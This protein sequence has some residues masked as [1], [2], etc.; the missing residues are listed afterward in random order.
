MSFLSP[1]MRLVVDREALA[2]LG[3]LESLRECVRSGDR[4]RFTG[5]DPGRTILYAFRG[6]LAQVEV[7]LTCRNRSF[8]AKRYSRTVRPVPGW[9]LTSP[10]HAPTR[11]RTGA[12]TS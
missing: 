2:G 5:T 11:K 10:S 4:V 12:H 7:V 3:D 6:D 1:E 9:P 8:S